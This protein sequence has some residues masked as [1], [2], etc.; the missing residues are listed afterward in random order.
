MQKTLENAWFPGFLRVGSTPAR[1]QSKRVEAQEY[2]ISDPGGATG[3]D[4]SIELLEL[5]EL[6]P[7]LPVDLRRRCLA[8]VRG[9]PFDLRS[10]EDMGKQ[11]T[12]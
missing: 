7:Q 5:T 12:T 4:I 8:I 9:H 2:A 6:W 3:G 10:N 1:G 11:P